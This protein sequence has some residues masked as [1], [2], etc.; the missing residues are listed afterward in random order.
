MFCQFRTDSPNPKASTHK[1]ECPN[2]V[3][4]RNAG[5]NYAKFDKKATFLGVFPSA[6]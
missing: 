6:E 2:A 3:F 5:A 1:A 4:V